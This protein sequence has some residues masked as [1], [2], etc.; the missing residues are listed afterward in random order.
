MIALC[1][2]NTSYASLQWITR[3]E[4]GLRRSLFNYGE[5]ANIS[6]AQGRLR[7]RV[8]MMC[9]SRNSRDLFVRF[10]AMGSGNRVPRFR[11]VGW[12]GMDSGWRLRIIRKRISARGLKSAEKF[13]RGQGRL[14][15]R[16]VMLQHPA[17]Q[18]G[19]G[20][21]LHPLVDQSRDF[22]AQIGSVIQ[23]RQLETLQRGT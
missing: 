4:N 2:F 10:A 18:H 15:K 11:E 16:A 14:M 1:K 6:N 5:R 9:L 21:F 23:T 3:S 17:R 22:M 19:F 20:C 7:M 8:L 13:R 12:R